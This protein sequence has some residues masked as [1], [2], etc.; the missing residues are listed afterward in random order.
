MH[1]AGSGINR[2]GLVFVR[3]TAGKGY[4]DYVVKHKKCAHIEKGLVKISPIG[5]K[6]RLLDFGNGNCDEDATFTINENTV[7]FKLK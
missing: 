1:G 4:E 5:F 2:T 7:A 3:E 6:P